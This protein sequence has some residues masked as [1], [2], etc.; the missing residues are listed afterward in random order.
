MRE[1]RRERGRRA[2]PPRALR[3]HR[4]NPLSPQLVSWRSLAA[5]VV[6]GGGLLAGMKVMKRYKEEGECGVREERRG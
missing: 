5:T 1:G 3:S 4:T 2:G 6:L